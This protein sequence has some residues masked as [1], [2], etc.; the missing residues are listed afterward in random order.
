MSGKNYHHGDLREALLAA[1]E[2]VLSERG[3]GGFTLREC[4]RR[5]GVSHAAPKH[6][7]G[8]AR[9][10]LAAIA[11]RG[12]E[13]LT[14]KLKKEL[15]SA[16]DLDSEMIATTR[17]YVGFATSHPEHFRLMFRSDLVHE[18]D[19]LLAQ[20]AANT[21]TA[22]TNV[23]LRQRGEQEVSAQ[24]LNKQLKARSLVKDIL[25]GWSQIHGLA[26][27]ALEQHLRMVPEED[28]DAIMAENAV[29]IG[30]IMRGK[31]SETGIKSGGVVD[32]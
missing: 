5:A 25:I 13:Q 22:L 28:M 24:D 32:D 19:V 11:A 29:R 6:H 7:F 10:L 14:L 30:H 4:A 21:Y 15:A 17:A 27:L 26:T 31:T 1:G 2:K 3:Y 12:F 20:A 23:I 18:E 16:R 8:D 9:T